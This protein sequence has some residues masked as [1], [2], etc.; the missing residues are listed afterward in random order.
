MAVIDY[1]A[2]NR[3]IARG[4]RDG[5]SLSKLA[6]RF[7]ITKARV[8][9]IVARHKE[10]TLGKDPAAEDAKSL[11]GIARFLAAAKNSKL[12]GKKTISTAKCKDQP[13]A[14]VLEKLDD[15]LRGRASFDVETLTQT[16]PFCTIEVFTI[17]PSDTL[18]KA[19]RHPTSTRTLITKLRARCAAASHTMMARCYPHWIFVFTFSRY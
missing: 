15:F 6:K 18:S 3:E 2:R 8:Q 1:R 4:V 5:Q 13:A 12:L 11:R 16:T 9:Q 14:A 19:P 7:G 17:A 10:R